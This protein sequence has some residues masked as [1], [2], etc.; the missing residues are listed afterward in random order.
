MRLFFLRVQPIAGATPTAGRQHPFNSMF[1]PNCHAFSENY[2]GSF[3]DHCPQREG[4][5]LG[6]VAFRGPSYFFKTLKVC[7]I[8]PLAPKCEFIYKI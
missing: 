1:K 3:W 4:G 6:P 7:Y 5:D 2:S 8:T